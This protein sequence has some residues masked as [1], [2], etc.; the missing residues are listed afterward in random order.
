MSL[1]GAAQRGQVLRGGSPR[2]DCCYLLS[3]KPELRVE[4]VQCMN[5]FHPGE[6]YFAFQICRA[7]EVAVPRVL[8]EQHAQDA[9]AFLKQAAGKHSDI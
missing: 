2:L 9:A 1:G 6:S 7:A 5:R 3:S 4:C 8:R